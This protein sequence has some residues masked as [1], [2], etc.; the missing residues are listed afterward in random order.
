MCRALCNHSLPKDY[1]EPELRTALKKLSDLSGGSVDIHTREI[2]LSCENG[3][4]CISVR[5]HKV[6]QKIVTGA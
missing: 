1:S 5:C 4:D 3:K 6:D 2:S